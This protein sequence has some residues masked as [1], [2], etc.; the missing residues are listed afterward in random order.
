VEKVLD[1]L[2]NDLAAGTL[3]CKR[4]F[5]NAA[6][7]RL[8]VLAYNVLATMK[9]HSLP[10]SWWKMRLKALRFHLLHLAGRLILHGRKVYLKIAPDH[11]SLPVY[12]E[13]RKRLLAFSSA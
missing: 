9:R 5:A 7:F 2:K 8:N 10:D 4:F 3:P 13:A 6:W 12:V 1:V 11:P